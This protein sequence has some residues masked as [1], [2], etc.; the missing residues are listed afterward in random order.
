MNF[1]GLK[2]VTSA[3]AGYTG[4]K[5]ILPT[6]YTMW[7]HTEAIQVTYDPSQVSYSDLLNVYWKHHNP[8]VTDTRYQSAIYYHSEEQEQLAK[9][10]VV[11]RGDIP[12]KI[13]PASH[14]HS[15]WTIASVTMSVMKPLLAVTEGYGQRK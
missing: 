8:K 13:A 9:K 2:G 1:A 7:D 10:S 3:R 15:S 14:F 12:V 4:G 11:H 5:A 6:Y